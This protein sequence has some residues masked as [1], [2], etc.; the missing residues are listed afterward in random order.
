M[1]STAHATRLLT[2]AQNKAIWAA[3]RAK[4]IDP[5]ELTGGRSIRELSTRDASA[6]LDRLN[7]K[8]AGSKPPRRNRAPK[9]VTRLISAEQIA[10]IHKLRIAMGW[11]QGE[12]GEHLKGKTYKSDPS[13]TMAVMN[14]SKDAVAVIEHLRK[15]LSRTLHYHGVKL[16]RPKSGE[17]SVKEIPAMMRALSPHEA[18]AA[19]FAKRC[20]HWREA[21]PGA[22]WAEW[23]DTA[24]LAN[25]RRASCPTTCAEMARLIERMEQEADA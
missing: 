17:P 9:D 24:K 12:L 21:N 19:L 6:L 25:G 11:T 23:A 14:S 18:L 20:A 10:L 7:G 5:H 15:V 3:A 1:N 8:P 13:R 16:G 22:D 4:G 2:P